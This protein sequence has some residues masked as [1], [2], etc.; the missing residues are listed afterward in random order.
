VFYEIPP[1][2]PRAGFV[3]TI[4][5]SLGNPLVSVVNGMATMRRSAVT[6]VA[7]KVVLIA[8]CEPRRLKPH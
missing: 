1:P 7:E 3:C 6:A 4:R 2:L 5:E 8:E